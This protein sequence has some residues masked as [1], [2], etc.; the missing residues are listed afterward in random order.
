MQESNTDALNASHYSVDFKAIKRDASFERVLQYYGIEL[1]GGRRAQ[2]KALCPFHRDTRPSLNVNLDRKVFNCFPCGDGGDIVKFVAKKEYPA[3]PEGHLLEAAQKLAEICG[4]RIDGYSRETIA[5]S[6]RT[7]RAPV[8]SAIV[9]QAVVPARESDASIVWNP[10]LTF[11]LKVDPAHPYLAKRELS[12][13]TVEVFGLGYCV[14]EKSIMRERIL[15]PIHNEQGELVAYAGRWPGDSGWPEGTDKYLLPPKFQKMRVLY[16]LNRLIDGMVRGQWPGHE[17]HVVVVEGFFG[18]FATHA[19]APCVALM[20]S[21][22]SADHLRLL[23]EANVKFVTLLL[24]G[25]AK[26]E[27]AEQCAARDQKYAAVVYQLSASGFFV[28][29]PRLELGEQPDT[30]DRRQLAQLVAAFT[31]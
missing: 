12:P 6:G 4:I 9:T 5:N 24:D 8:Q 22:V 30:I 14:S 21:A 10:A 26:P 18:A 13:E 28:T 7:D 27:T 16:N 15:I 29:A 31:T 17:R 3:D 19:L 2:R 1:R 25:P 20:G 11:R 23:H